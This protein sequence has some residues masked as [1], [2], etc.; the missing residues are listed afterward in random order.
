MNDNL[1]KNY[2]EMSLKDIRKGF[3]QF[4]A[5]TEDM[6]YCQEMWENLQQNHKK[7]RSQMI[8]RN[9]LPGEVYSEGHFI[10]AEEKLAFDFID[11]ENIVPGSYDEETQTLKIGFTANDKVKYNLHHFEAV[12][13]ASK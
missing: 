5:H 12:A 1:L 4:M 2:Y 3:D 11:Y 10:Q 13:K 7:Y 8:E 9:L 6:E